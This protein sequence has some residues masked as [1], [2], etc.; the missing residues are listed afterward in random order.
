VG[1]YGA[2]SVRYARIN[3]NDGVLVGLEGALLLSHR[4][5]V[6]L[7]GY[8][9][10]NEQR[11]PPSQSPDRDYLHFGY[12][13]FLVRYHVYIPN[14]PVY[15]S[16]AAL[17]GGGSVGL[18]STWDGDLYRENTDEFFIVEPQIGVH[19]NF[20][21]WMRMGLDGGYRLISGVGKFGF[22]N[23]NFSGLSLGA[24]IGFGW[25]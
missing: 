14:S 8:G 18:T 16:A 5:A 2:L 23:S 4:L 13:G 19:T 15:L 17:I 3:G 11:L 22:T 10:S 24:N 1:G 12:A 9:W 20:T 25:F 6:G 7:A 21:K